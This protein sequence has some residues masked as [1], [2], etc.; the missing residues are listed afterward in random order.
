MLYPSGFIE[1]LKARNPIENVIS[2]YVELKRA[3]SNMVGL[4]PFHSERTPSFT[5]FQDDFH[6]FGCSA[7]GDVITFVMRMENLE[8]RDAVAYLADRC[9]MTLPAENLSGTSQKAV[10]TR[11]RSFAMNKIAARAFYDALNSD[12]GTQAR[13]Y[14]SKRQLSRA[15]CV[16]FGLGYAPDSFNYLTDILTKEGYSTDEISENF[17]CGISKKNGK[18]FD[19]F[20]N[21]VIFPIIDLSGNIIAFGGRVMDDSKPKYLNSSDT[22]VFKKSK[23][24]FALNFAKS[25]LLGDREGGGSASTLVRSGELILCEGYMDVISMHQAGFT[26]A[27]ATLGTAITSEHARIISRFAK[28]VYLAYDSDSAG[29]NAT[30]KAIEKLSEVGIDA[31]VIKIEGAKD[32]DEYIKKYGAASFA[33]ILGS[34]D[35]E[36]DFKLKAILNKYDLSNADDKIRAVQ[37][38]CRMLSDIYSPI[39]REVY[40]KRASEITGISEETINAEI[41]KALRGKASSFRKKQS[42]DTQKRLLRY[43]DRI[44]K[45]SAVNPAAASVEERLL[46]ILL[47]HPELF[48]KCKELKSDDFITSFN[49]SVYER[50]KEIYDSGT[51]DTSSLNEYFSPEEMGRIMNMRYEREKLSSN[52]VDALSEQIYTL[53]KLKDKKD[54]KSEELSFIDSINKIK[55]EKLKGGSN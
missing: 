45:E 35:G 43:D 52:G 37:D 44:N 29:Q 21:R 23:N 17:L 6:C 39:K 27:V 51:S 20:R 36:V 28:T 11:E 8:Y 10:L 38:I 33:K 55:A 3:G 26:N 41:K 13:E 7:G 4:C 30:K 25:A 47:L 31:K 48:E 49:R 22:V 1:E 15:T 12:I 24:L 5:V 46:G 34:S 9:G 14:F 54:A 50:L 40:T 42:D 18:P 19:M 32:P 16:H 53:K 2:R